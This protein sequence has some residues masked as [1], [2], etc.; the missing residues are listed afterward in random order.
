M[1]T[2]N[3]TKKAEVLLQPFSLGVPVRGINYE[4]LSKI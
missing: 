4:T 1:P 2:Y 3:A